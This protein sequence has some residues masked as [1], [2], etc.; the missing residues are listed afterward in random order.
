M[1]YLFSKAE[2]VSRIQIIALAI[3][4]FIAGIVIGG[5]LK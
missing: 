4:Y 3:A 1:N 5:A 2:S